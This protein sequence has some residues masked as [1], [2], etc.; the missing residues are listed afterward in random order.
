MDITQEGSHPEQEG[1][2]I[3]PIPRLLTY[4]STG[5][6]EAPPRRHHGGP[7]LGVE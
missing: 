5:C 6:Y 1:K 3:L 4:V 7:F 2:C